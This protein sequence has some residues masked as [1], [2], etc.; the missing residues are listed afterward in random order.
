MCCVVV[1]N[2]C[3]FSVYSC[4]LS[5]YSCKLPVYPCI[6]SVYSQ[7]TLVYL[8]FPCIGHNSS[9]TTRSNDRGGFRH[10]AFL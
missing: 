5:V 6:F 8:I 1:V 7:Y 3:I 10:S 9:T 2:S 4:I